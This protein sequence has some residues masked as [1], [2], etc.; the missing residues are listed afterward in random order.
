MR[1]MHSHPFEGTANGKPLVH[2]PNN[3]RMTAGMLKKKN[4]RSEILDF[5]TNNNVNCDMVECASHEIMHALRKSIW[6]T[7]GAGAVHHG[8]D[9][10]IFTFKLAVAFGPS[11]GIQFRAKHPRRKQ[12]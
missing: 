2:G 4:W 1:F 8:R 7:P 9:G 3:E 11:A 5:A 12:N 10:T 6:L